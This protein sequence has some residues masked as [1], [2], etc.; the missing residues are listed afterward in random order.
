MKE[1][2]YLDQSQRD[3]GSVTLHI[4]DSSGNDIWNEQA[5]TSHVGWTSLFLCEQGGEY[6]LLRYLPGMWQGYCTYTYTLFTL[7][8]GAEHAV[9]SN[10]IEFDVNGVNKLDA[11]NMI[12]FAEEVNGLLEKST[13]LLSSEGGEYSFGPSS[14]DRFFERYSWLDGMPKFMQTVTTLRHLVM[15]GKNVSLHDFGRA[16]TAFEGFNMDFQI[17]DLSEEVLGKEGALL[18]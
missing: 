1:S 17:R 15:D 13:L 16:L 5:G 6:Y 18:F 4:Y 9:R 11:P 2:I 8:G 12:A 14:A 7:E 3:N 10:T